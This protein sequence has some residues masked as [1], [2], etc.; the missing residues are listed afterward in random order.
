MLCIIFLKSRNIANGGA[1][2]AEV[3]ANKGGINESEPGPTTPHFESTF[4]A[5]TTPPTDTSSLF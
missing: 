1:G 2:K 5:A 4:N 3:L